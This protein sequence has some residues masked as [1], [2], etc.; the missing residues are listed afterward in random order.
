MKPHI[1]KV[2]DQWLAF[3]RGDSAPAG[4]TAADTAHE[5]YQLLVNGDYSVT[6]GAS[7]VET[8]QTADV[9]YLHANEPARR[10]K[11]NRHR[12]VKTMCRSSGSAT[13]HE[14]ALRT[15]T[16]TSFDG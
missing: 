10:P 14:I 6:Y 2:L 1:F 8:R 5:A 4:F 9:Y 11:R 13:R 12:A 7:A 15:A 16:G 3:Y